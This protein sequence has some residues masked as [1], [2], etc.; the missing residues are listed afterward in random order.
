M[1]HDAE[2][3]SPVAPVAVMVNAKSQPSRDAEVTANCNPQPVSGALVATPA[4]SFEP[5][6]SALVA[7]EP[8]NTSMHNMHAPAQ[9]T[10]E[11]KVSAPSVTL[12]EG[13]VLAVQAGVS[14]SQSN[15]PLAP[16]GSPRAD[17]AVPVEEELD[18]HSKSKPSFL[19]SPGKV[20][21]PEE[22]VQAPGEQPVLE[23][24][25]LLPMRSNVEDLYEAATAA[26][27]TPPQ[28]PPTPCADVSGELYDAC[29]AAAPPPQQPSAPA[30]DVTA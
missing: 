10:A 18:E 17:N 27:A 21:H 14:E 15:P 28:Q 30:V 1:Q 6:A 24:K 9:S 12:Q 25:L 20:K 7:P 5:V 19:G 11:V 2:L 16:A 23:P 29:A 26:A 4:E 3:S 8:T 13:N 22:V